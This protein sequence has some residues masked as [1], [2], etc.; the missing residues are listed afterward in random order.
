MRV[1]HQKETMSALDCNL[2]DYKEMKS[3]ETDMPDVGNPIIFGAGFRLI[4]IRRPS[5]V[6]HIVRFDRLGVKLKGCAVF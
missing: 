4:F 3:S 6:S 1:E 2:W 5:T